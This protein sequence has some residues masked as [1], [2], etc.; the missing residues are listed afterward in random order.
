MEKE[1]LRI[2]IAQINSTVGDLESNTSKII[3]YAYRAESSGADI[4]TFP[5]LAL[6]GYPPEDLLL[7][8]KFIK[9][10][11]SALKQLANSLNCGLV[12]IVGFVDKKG[13]DIYNAAAIIYRKKIYGVYHKM[14]LPNYGVF[15]EKRYFSIGDNPAI[16]RLGR[17]IFGVNICEDIWHKEGPTMR[18][19]Q[20]AATLILNINASPYYAGRARERQKI[21]QQQAVTNRTVIVYTNLTGGQDELVFD[22]QSMIVDDKGNLV[23]RLE[24]FKEDLLITDLDIPIKKVNLKKKIVVISEKVPIKKKKAALPKKIIQ[25]L[26]STPEVYQALVMGLRDYVTKNGFNKAV[27]GLS[28]GID[29]SLVATLAVD[30]LGSENVFGVFM[31]SRYSSYDS[32]EDA[33]QLSRNLGIRLIQISIEQIFK[34][35][36]VVLEPH[37]LGSQ[38]DITEENL[39]ARIRGNILMALSNKFGWLVL[40]TGNKSEMSTGYATL[41]GDMAGGFAVIKDVPKTLV[42][43][44]ARYRNLQGA[45]IPERIFTKAPTAELRPNQKDSDTLPVYEELDPILKAYIEEDKDFTSIAS[46]GFEQ[47]MV[48]R[49]LAM[50]DRSEYKRR[51]APPGIKITPKAFGRDRR[52]PIT[53]KY[54]G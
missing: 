48:E 53:N 37:F 41:Y 16:F 38:R 9:D 20:S 5:E 6:T 4:I 45:V 39:Q 34:M 32:E 15:D 43:R 23:S 21:I 52:M 3:Q 12:V 49:V 13:K 18:Q 7:K 30:A 54:R 29:S 22:G 10:N 50:V 42:Y 25:P 31:P 51:Q 24:A 26:E 36:L 1:R 19:A 33:L 27:L 47:S 2:A 14:F 17:V 35:Y 28:G 11:I 8:A 46:L 40:T 44:L